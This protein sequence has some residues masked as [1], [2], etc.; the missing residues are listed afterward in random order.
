MAGPMLFRSVRLQEFIG[1]KAVRQNDAIQVVV[2]PDGFVWQEPSG[3]SHTL[4]FMEI[5]SLNAGSYQL[6]LRLTTGSDL[7]ISQLGYEYEAFILQTFSA[8]NHFVGQALYL[9]EP[10]LLEVKG[11]YIYQNSR[12]TADGMAESNDQGTT[13]FGLY[14]SSLMVYPQSGPIRRVPL[15]QIDAVEPSAWQIRLVTQLGEEWTIRRLG[16]DRDAFVFALSQA[17]QRQTDRAFDLLHQIVVAHEAINRTI[18][19]PSSQDLTAAAWLLRE[20]RAADPDALDHV[21][22]GLFPRLDA[23]LRQWSPDGYYAELADRAQASGCGRPIIGIRREQAAADPDQDSL[24]LPAFWMIVPVRSND[25]TV[26]ALEVIASQ[27]LAQATYIFARPPEL[28][29]WPAVWRDLNLAL[30]AVDFRREAL[31]LSAADLAKPDR[32][33]DQAALRFCPALSRL[34]DHYLGR[35]IHRGLT[36]WRDQLQHIVVKG[37]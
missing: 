37:A 6:R 23:I 15:C 11:D 35:I 28:S 33:R 29:A 19:E 30:E 13:R 12:L 8:W 32:Q 4:P 14:D 20:G 34:R 22:P 1:S 25:R 27:P 3:H 2:Q 17:L 36:G 21:C 26:T 5:V 18:P 9:D 7:V 31:Y 10:C 24:L 16:H